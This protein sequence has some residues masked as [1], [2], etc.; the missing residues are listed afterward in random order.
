MSL[1]DIIKAALENKLAGV[2]VALPARIEKYD[3]AKQQANVKPLIKYE[4]QDGTA[5]SLPVINNVP[6]VWP[7]S[8]K[9]VL[10]F[11]ITAGDTVLLVFSE[12]SLDVWKSK[13]GEVEPLDRRKHD[14]SDAIAIPGLFSFANVPGKAD[15]SSAV[16]SFGSA[17]LALNNN[18]KV[19]FG[20]SQAELLDLIDQLL[21]GIELMTI[22]TSIG[23][24][25]PINKATFTAIRTNLAK[26]KGTL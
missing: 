25:P 23:P 15:S 4:Y 5:D 17:K 16:F 13:G 1:P 14:I 22:A 21:E 18:N 24:Q 3:A 11:P 20:N 12:R 26:I 2:H 19:A 7:G 10:S 6:I 8:T 9:G